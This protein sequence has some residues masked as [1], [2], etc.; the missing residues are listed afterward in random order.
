MQYPKI[1]QP[2]H[3]R[4]EQIDDHAENRNMLANGHNGDHEDKV[5][6]IFTPVKP[7]YSRNFMIIDTVYNSAPSSHLGVPGPDGDAHDIGFNGLSSIPDDV[8]AELPADCL[9]A[10]EQAL[11][12]ET[13]WKA[14][15]GTE[16]SSTLRRAP[17]ID[18]GVV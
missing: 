17:A 10:F 5:Q 15:W 3:A 8:K 9:K 4:W 6:T 14:Q 11:E 2:T 13:Q 12:K 7:I 16:S 1:M 18:K